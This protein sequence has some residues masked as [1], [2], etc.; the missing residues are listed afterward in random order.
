MIYLRHYWILRF[1]RDHPGSTLRELITWLE[2]IPKTTRIDLDLVGKY[3]IFQ[4]VLITLMNNGLLEKQDHP[5][6]ENLRSY[7][8]SAKAIRLLT[9]IDE[10]S[11]QFPG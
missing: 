1:F 6:A 8:L 10:F 2:G 11:H 4:Q 3:P 9:I 5:A 7:V